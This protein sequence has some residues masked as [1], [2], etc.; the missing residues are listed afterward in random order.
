MQAW[1]LCRCHAI[2]VTQGTASGQGQVLGV[3]GEAGSWYVCREGAVT[4]PQCQNPARLSQGQR[5]TWGCDPGEVTG[6]THTAR[7]LW[8]GWAGT[9]GWTP[10]EGTG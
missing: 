5:G 2:P 10:V 1:N 9:W 3:A 4:A 6:V 7:P 8:R